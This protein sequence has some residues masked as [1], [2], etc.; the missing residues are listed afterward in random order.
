MGVRTRGG[1]A[2][3]KMTTR[4]RGVDVKFNTYRGDYFF[5]PFLQTEK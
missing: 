2:E 4:E 1:E 5:I 3:E